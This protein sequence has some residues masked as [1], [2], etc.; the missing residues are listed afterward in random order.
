M[1]GLFQIL[2]LLLWPILIPLSFLFKSIVIRRR[3]LAN[4]NNSANRLP[5][6]VISVGNVY[7]GGTGKTPIVIELVKFLHEK[8]K[9]VTVLSRGYKS[10]LAKND[11]GYYGKNGLTTNSGSKSGI[12]ADEAKLVHNNTGCDSVFGV[13]RYEAARWYLE[14]NDAPDVWILDD[15]FQHLSIARD[16]DIVV[17]DFRKDLSKEG[18]FPWGLMREPLSAVKDADLTVFTRA[19]DLNNF[20]KWADDFVVEKKCILSTQVDNGFCEI[21]LDGKQKMLTDVELE[22]VSNNFA[23]VLGV[24]NPDVIISELKSK[25]LVPRSI[26]IAPDHV[27]F[28]EKKMTEM[29]KNF[30]AVITT[31]KDYSRCAELLHACFKRVIIK[32]IAFNF[33][34][35]LNNHIRI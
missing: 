10:G 22:A 27:S 13:K 3:R 4:K 16:I 23:V 32:E 6:V 20:P 15:G 14:S 1:K 5:G 2:R 19:N 31:A 30:T 25:N 17:C 34:E 29:G 33:S 7:V 11:F 26:E 12:C 28:D 9:R 21:F 24:A 18:V 8:G 35:D